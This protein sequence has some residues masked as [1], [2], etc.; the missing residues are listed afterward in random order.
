LMLSTRYPLD[1]CQLHKS[2]ED[3]NTVDSTSGNCF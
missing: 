3:G 2:I 1:G